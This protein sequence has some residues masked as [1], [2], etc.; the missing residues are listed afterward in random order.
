MTKP[1]IELVR[2]QLSSAG[3]AVTS[4]G[5]I[6]AETIDEKKLVDQHYYAIASKATITPPAELAVPTEKFK[7]F[8][9]E[10]WKSVLEEGRAKTALEAGQVLDLDGPSLDAAWGAAKDAGNIIKLG[11]GFYC[12]RIGEGDDR[13][14]TFN[15]FYMSLR[16][17]FTKPGGESSPLARQSRR[18][19]D[20]SNNPTP[21]RQNGR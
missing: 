13:L 10:D 5:D 14:Y 3:V 11:G 17:R 21:S 12:G 2:T 20:V 16:E 1:T 15:A 4:E 18:P 8:F 9:G 19:N 7:E 6:S